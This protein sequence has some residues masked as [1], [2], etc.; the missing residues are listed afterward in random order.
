MDSTHTDAPAPAAADPPQQPDMAMLLRRLDS[1]EKTVSAIHA[2][3]VRTES[4]VNRLLDH[5]GLDAQG[6]PVQRH[7]EE[8]PG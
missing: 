5:V 8:Y 3:S 4:K 6:N 2:R 1:M 7:P